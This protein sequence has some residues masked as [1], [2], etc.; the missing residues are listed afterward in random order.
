[1]STAT[2]TPDLTPRAVNQGLA[3]LADG[4]SEAC[5]LSTGD[6]GE[7]L[8]PAREALWPCLY[9]WGRWRW[10]QPLL[11]NTCLTASVLSGQV[12]PIGQRLLIAQRS[13]QLPRHLEITEVGTYVSEAGMRDRQLACTGTP[14]DL[15]HR[16]SG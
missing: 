2:F 8:G 5:P 1:M 6:S 13:S 10:V 9:P 3:V 7:G 14:P 4:P 15:T 16:D 11:H 12:R